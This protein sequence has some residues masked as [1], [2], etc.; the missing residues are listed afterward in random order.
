M[1]RRFWFAVSSMLVVLG[2]WSWLHKPAAPELSYSDPKYLAQKN[3]R[4]INV[5]FVGNRLTSANMMPYHLTLLSL[6]QRNQY[7]HIY[8]EQ[9]NAQGD[10][11][12]EIHWNMGEV[13]SRIMKDAWDYVFLQEDSIVPVIGGERV[14]FT[15][16][17]Q[18]FID[19]IRQ[20]GNLKEGVAVG[21]E[22]VRP[23]ESKPILLGSWPYLDGKSMQS[24]YR[25]HINYSYESHYRMTQSM[26]SKAAERFDVSALYLAPLFHNAPAD[27]VVYESD[28]ATPTPAGSYMIALS[29]YKFLFNITKFEANTYVPYNVDAEIAQKLIAYVE[30]FEG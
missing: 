23:T 15:K 9:Q 29:I 21:S 25:K 20:F 28:G 16:Y 4:S 24:R 17:A 12:L 13:P 6:S 14:I 18:K 7:Y 1:Y 22:Q 19:L 26:Y 30:G 27:V 3:S 2:L 10:K 8:A 5:F 11:T